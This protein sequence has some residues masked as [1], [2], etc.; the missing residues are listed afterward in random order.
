MKRRTDHALV[1]MA[2]WPEPGRAKTRLTPE[3]TLSQAAELACC[4]LLDTLDV[5][6]AAGEDRWIAFAPASAWTRFRQLVGPEVGL[7]HAEFES[8][9]DSLR[10]AQQT[11]LAMGYKSVSL[12]ASD[13]P[14]LPPDRYLDAF[15][16]LERA[17]VAIGPCA[18]GGYYLLAAKRETPSLFRRIA[19]STST[20]YGDTLGRA[21]E[22]GLRVVALPACS[23]VD[24]AAD[25]ELLY[26]ELASRSE[27]CRSLELL[28]RLR[29]SVASPV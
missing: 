9:G 14:H 2:K 20:V 17:D 21:T 15:E 5:A 6:R 8:F 16:A 7:I 25:L 22:A 18:D 1:F 4:F 24:T 12:V 26:A 19:W 10:T 11:A 27:S 13:V 28:L 23:D 29:G 3:L